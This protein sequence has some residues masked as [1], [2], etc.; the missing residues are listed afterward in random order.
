MIYFNG[1]AL[2]SIAPVRVDDIGVSSVRL[3]AEA[4]ERPIVFGSDFV[5]MRGGNRTISITFAL[6]TNDRTVRQRQL[7]RINAWADVGKVHRLTIP[8]Y[9]D[10]Y[11]ECACTEVPS[12]SIKQWWENKL[13]LT[14]TTYDNPY[15]TS[16]AEKSVPCGTPFFVLGSAPDGPLMR[17]EGTL[18]ASDTLTYSNGTDTMVFGTY[19]DRPTGSFVIDLNRQTASVGTE[20]I[21]P[22]YTFNSRFLIPANGEQTITG[23]GTIYWRERW[24]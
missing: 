15:F 10:L 16:I 6:L 5:R 7:M 21:M 20:S 12:P 19:N 13:R 24:L 17:I 22:G 14:F 23:T 3:S 9:P 11:L 18:G 8:D 2:E 4:R 1:T